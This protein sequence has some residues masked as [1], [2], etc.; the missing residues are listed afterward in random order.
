V[1]IK[2]GKFSILF[3]IILKGNFM[4]VMCQL[5]WLFWIIHY[6]RQFNIDVCDKIMSIIMNGL[7]MFMICM[8]IIIPELLNC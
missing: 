4:E 3:T 7:R 2:I 1:L 6:Q 8:I 5:L